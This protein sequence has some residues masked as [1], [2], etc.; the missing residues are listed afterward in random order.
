M[1]LKTVFVIGA[2][3]VA[4]MASC[5]NKSVTSLAVNYN[6][7]VNYYVEGDEIKKSDFTVTATYSDKSTGEIKDFTIDGFSNDAYKFSKDDV[8]KY[9]KE[10]TFKYN[11][12]SA[13]Y[14]FKGS[15]TDKATFKTSIKAKMDSI[16]IDTYKAYVSKVFKVSGS[17]WD[18]E[19]E[20]KNDEL[21]EYKGYTVYDIKEL[22]EETLAFGFNMKTEG[23][24]ICTVVPGDKK[25]DPE[26]FDI[27]DANDILG[28]PFI[29]NSEAYETFL[30]DEVKDTVK[31][32]IT[33]DGYRIDAPLGAT[34]G[35]GNDVT[36]DS[37]LMVKKLKVDRGE[38]Y[39]CDLE[40]VFDK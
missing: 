27:L 8:S 31:Y 39:I 18:E 17:T 36:Y 22:D 21:I 14:T 23:E 26:D 9:S 13:A 30:G 34:Q 7:K 5:N 28:F 12:K 38:G 24:E 3:S 4:L 37:N 11:D 33:D 2:S 1:K 32:Y 20:S 19:E 15:L 40:V 35:A 25:Y 6:G 16:S 10:F 29:F